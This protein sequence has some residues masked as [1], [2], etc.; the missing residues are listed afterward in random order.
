MILC[1][2]LY[3]WKYGA[4]SGSNDTKIEVVGQVEQKLQQS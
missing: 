1:F 3:R 4:N 2:C